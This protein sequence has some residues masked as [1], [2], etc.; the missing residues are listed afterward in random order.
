M[1]VMRNLYFNFCFLFSFLFLNANSGFSESESPSLDFN[2]KQKVTVDNVLSRCEGLNY[3][4][5]LNT[6]KKRPW[7]K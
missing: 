1:R 3:Y 2:E 5:L 4:D 6:K 7:N